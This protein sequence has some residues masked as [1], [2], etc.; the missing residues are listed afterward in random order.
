MPLNRAVLLARSRW[1]NKPYSLKICSPKAS[2]YLL[3]LGKQ[4]RP[5][6]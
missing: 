6:F 5:F 3:V 2:Y 4:H 1:L